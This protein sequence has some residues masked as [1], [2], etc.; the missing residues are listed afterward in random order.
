VVGCI[1]ASIDH[2]W[3]QMPADKG[4]GAFMMIEN[5]RR[6]AVAHFGSPRGE[7]GWI[8]EDNKGMNSIATSTDSE[9]ARSTR[10]TGSTKRR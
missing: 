3:T 1:S 2:A 8:L 4:G 9:I 10:P 6:D 5:I 7:I